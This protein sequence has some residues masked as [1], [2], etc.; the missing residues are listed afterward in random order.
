MSET[1]PEPGLE[2]DFTG[3]PPAG[4]ANPEDYMS[5]DQQAVSEDT[6][7]TYGRTGEPETTPHDDVVE[8]DDEEAE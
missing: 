6:G 5:N 7:T 1:T 8:D 3:T 2:E 4:D